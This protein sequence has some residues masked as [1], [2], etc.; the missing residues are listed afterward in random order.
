M[1]YRSSNGF[2]LL[3]SDT[4]LS[5]EGRGLAIRATTDRPFRKELHMPVRRVAAILAL[6]SIVGAPWAFASEAHHELKRENTPRITSIS[7]AF[8]DSLG[9]WLRRAVGKAGCMIDPLG[10]LCIQTNPPSLPS[11]PSGRPGQ[12]SSDAGCMLDPAGCSAA[13]R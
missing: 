8:V 1:L 9:S 7:S 3:V 12:S 2:P 11:Q 5:E 6:G 13:A 4:I 10:G